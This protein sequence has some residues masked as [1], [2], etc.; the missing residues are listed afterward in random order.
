MEAKNDEIRIGIRKCVNTLRVT[1][2]G[3]LLF[4]VWSLIKGVMVVLIDPDRSFMEDL[5]LSL[6]PVMNIA[7]ALSV[8]VVFWVIEMLFR[9]SVWRGARREADGE[10]KRKNFYLLIAAF[11]IIF[12]FATILINVWTL[13][14]GNSSVGNAAASLLLEVT[15][16][17]ISVNLVRSA[18][19]IRKLRVIKAQTEGDK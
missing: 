15:S 7:L 10:G 5:D 13:L 17:V 14:R 2:D 16:F 6:S 9:L 12:S 11:V 1:A 19:R 8:V 4:G 3:V 18:F